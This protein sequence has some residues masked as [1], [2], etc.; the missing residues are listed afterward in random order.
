MGYVILP[1]NKS[2]S[3]NSSESEDEFPRMFSATHL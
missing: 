1:V 2:G 3:R